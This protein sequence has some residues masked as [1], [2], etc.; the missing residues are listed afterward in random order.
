MLCQYVSKPRM[1][2][3]EAVT[4]VLRYFKGRAGQGMLFVCFLQSQWR[5]GNQ[6][7]LHLIIFSMNRPNILRSIVM[8]YGKRFKLESLRSCMFPRHYNLLICLPRH[9]CPLI[10][11][12]SCP[13][14]E[15]TTSTSHLDGSFRNKHNTKHA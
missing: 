8:L 11:E 9:C 5:L 14:W 3:M 1:P 7:Q 10:S 4:Y 2:H 12:L 6:S 13:R 15:F